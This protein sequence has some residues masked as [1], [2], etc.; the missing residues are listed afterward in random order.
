[1]VS[2][3]TTFAV[4]RPGTGWLGGLLYQII[5]RPMGDIG[6]RS[7]KGGGNENQGQLLGMLSN[8]FGELP[9][10][11]IVR[12]RKAGQQADEGGLGGRPAKDVFPGNS[13]PKLSAGAGRAVGRQGNFACGRAGVLMS[14]RAEENRTSASGASAG[15]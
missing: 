5:R 11:G 10:A 1:W 14:H 4:R 13:L 9:V 15:K 6:N 8:P 12:G 3:L 2:H 7:Q